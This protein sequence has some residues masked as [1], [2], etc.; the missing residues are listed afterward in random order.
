M[1]SHLIYSGW[2]NLQNSAPSVW[3]FT[4]RLQSYGFGLMVLLTSNRVLSLRYNSKIIFL[5]EIHMFYLVWK[6]IYITFEYIIWITRLI[7]YKKT[8]CANLLIQILPNI[9]QNLSIFV[10]VL[11]KFPQ[12]L[13][14]PYVRHGGTSQKVLMWWA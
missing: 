3:S 5:L 6:V 7:T 8:G 2:L 9:R 4:E 1:S 12:T 10:S 11:K 13:A 14:L